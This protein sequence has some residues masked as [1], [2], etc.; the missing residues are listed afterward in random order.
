MNQ[1]IKQFIEEHEAEMIEM[2]RYLHQHPELSL[3]EFE[4]TRYIASKFDELGLEYR[5]M[6]LTG[7]MTEIKGPQ[8]GKQSYC[9]RIWCLIH[10]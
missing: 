2:R 9:V 4:T 1:T 5:L 7:V 6:D 3:E 8:P 10:Q